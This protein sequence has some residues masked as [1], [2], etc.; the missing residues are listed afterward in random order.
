[1][2]TIAP[3]QHTHFREPNTMAKRGLDIE[4]IEVDTSIF[5]DEEEAGRVSMSMDRDESGGQP[6]LDRFRT[7][8]G[9]DSWAY[10]VAQDQGLPFM[11]GTDYPLRECVTLY[12][13]KGT[14]IAGGLDYLISDKTKFMIDLKDKNDK[15]LLA[16]EYKRKR[17]GSY[18]KVYDQDKRVLIGRIQKHPEM[19][20]RRLVIT[21]AGHTLCFSLVA[22]FR[23]STFDLYR[24]HEQEGV[25]I[26]MVSFK[27]KEENVPDAVSKRVIDPSIL[28][29]R[30]PEKGSEEELKDWE[31]TLI[32]AA[33]F[34]VN[35]LWPRNHME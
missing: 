32:I 24:L 28:A 20:G 31:K 19:L 4:T 2:L 23:S 17:F 12:N 7:A 13:Q 8:V 1:M 11:K 22:P 27:W 26:G 21:N 9:A 16:L 18:L 30:W 10:I 5:S 29:L 15:V 34:H 14:P 6:K 3:S 33:M 25:P 35:F